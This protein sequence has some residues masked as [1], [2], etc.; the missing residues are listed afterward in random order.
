MVTV[1]DAKNFLKDYRSVDNLR[2]RDLAISTADD[3]GLGDLLVEQVEFA[4]VIVISKA[5][6][7][8]EEAIFEIIGVL[9]SLNPSAEI[10]V[11]SNSD[12]AIKQVLGTGRFDMEKA[13]QSPAWIKELNNEH[14]P[15]TEEYGISSFAFRARKPFHPAR[16][17]EY[18]SLIHI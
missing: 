10:I 9:K 13:M 3:R 1:V 5:D 15:E 4:D 2:D 18:L 6:L 17:L 16:L 11:S 8:N 7:V 14:T 12:I